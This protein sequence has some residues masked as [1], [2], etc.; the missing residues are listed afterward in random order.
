MRIAIVQP[1]RLYWAFVNDY[2]NFMVPQA[3][4]ALAAVARAAGHEVEIL[5]CL[6]MKMGWASLEARLRRMRP[7]VV[8]AGENHAVFSHEV[9]KLMSLVKSIDPAIHTIVGGT[10]FAFL[11]S[12]YLGG[13][14]DAPSID[15]IARGEGEETFR[16]LLAELEKVKPEPWTVD[17]VTAR[18][19]SEVVRAPD[20]KLIAD[21]DTLPRPAYDLLPMSKYG[22]SKFLFAANGSTIH[23]S[24][25]CPSACDFCAFWINMADHKK[26]PNGEDVLVA[27]WRTKS[28]EKTIEEIEYLQHA[29]GKSYFV[30]VDDTFNV[31]PKWCDAFAEEVLRRGLKFRFYA[32]LR[33]DLIL[34]DEKL[35]VFEKLVR[36]GLIH[37]AIGVERE[38]D[39]ELKNF[40]KGFQTGSIIR[41][42]MEL[43]ETK[44]PHVFKQTTYLVGLREDTRETI[45][46]QGEYAKSLKPD[47]A[48]FHPLTPVPGTKLWKEA[49][50]KGWVKDEDFLSY[51]WS[52]PVME[53]ETLS[54]DEID[55]ALFDCSRRFVSVPWFMRGLIGRGDYTRRMYIWWLLVLGKM[56]ITDLLNFKNPAE[57]EAFRGLKE[58]AWYQT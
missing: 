15:C 54:L 34:R 48:G 8:C 25:G 40:H 9:V 41:K 7:D 18:R 11:D 27:R 52:T 44:Y 29:F 13:K 1:P 30:F 19:G 55:Q 56:T 33:A 17:G 50:A 49:L 4:P 26:G 3:P 47:Y 5:D 10:H 6:P 23:H 20:R 31:D 32:F 16:V 57:C 39:E 58:P 21:L 22:D 51:D 2:D 36:A 12:W 53:T 45:L 35:G 43:L 42:C 14:H 46:A 24:R 38:S 28:V 37:A